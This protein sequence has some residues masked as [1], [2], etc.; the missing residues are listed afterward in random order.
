MDADPHLTSPTLEIV[1]VISVP[2]NFI[3]RDMKKKKKIHNYIGEKDFF[4]FFWLV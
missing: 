3:D 4:F 2:F 1:F